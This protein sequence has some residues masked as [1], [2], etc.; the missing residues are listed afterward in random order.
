M[1]LAQTATLGYSNYM[2]H[3]NFID[4]KIFFGIVLRRCIA[5]FLTAIFL[6]SFPAKT[7]ADFFSHPILA[8][9]IAA[10]GTKIEN[11]L[12]V[13]QVTE[14]GVLEV[15]GSNSFDS[16]QI[17]KGDFIFSN[18]SD[19]STR[20]STFQFRNSPGNV[21]KVDIWKIE[22]EYIVKKST[23]VTLMP[24]YHTDYIM[25][26]GNGATLYEDHCVIG[27][28]FTDED[29]TTY[30]FPK[31]AYG[32]SLK[33]FLNGCNDTDKAKAFFSLLEKVGKS[34]KLTSKKAYELFIEKIGPQ[35]I[36]KIRVLSQKPQ[37]LE[38]ILSKMEEVVTATPTT[39]LSPA[40]K[41]GGSPVKEYKSSVVNPSGSNE[42]GIKTSGKNTYKHKHLKAGK[43][44]YLGESGKLNF[45]G[46]ASTQHNRFPGGTAPGAKNLGHI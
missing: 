19:C 5:L 10:A 16:L 37:L 14:S 15:K 24:K 41:T 7:Y 8:L 45:T 11:N 2:R 9:H 33:A 36:E 22:P 39:S 38:V 20:H 28:I 29:L 30:F 27:N 34:G 3:G 12:W 40:A 17:Y 43:T 13:I 44:A 6:V 35:T 23:P 46:G 21:P 31:E 42:W 25:N 26:L 32:D 1:A 4:S 18:G